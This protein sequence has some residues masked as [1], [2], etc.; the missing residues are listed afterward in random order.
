MSD[1]Q[2]S[3]RMAEPWGQVIDPNQPAAM[4][5]P[6]TPAGDQSQE[7]DATAPRKVK[8]KKAME[9]RNLDKMIELLK[10]AD[11]EEATSKVSDLEPEDIV[12]EEEV[13]EAL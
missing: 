10:K 11:M 2:D 9:M 1:T 3:G 12:N 5:Q 13:A 4:Q 6:P 8:A 7:Q